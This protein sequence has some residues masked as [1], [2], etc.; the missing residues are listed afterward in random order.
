MHQNYYLIKMQ[1]L[2]RASDA[3]GAERQLNALLGRSA[4]QQDERLPARALI[5]YEITASDLA[6][7]VI[8]GMLGD[9]T[10]VAGTAFADW[11]VFSQSEDDIT[12]GEAGYWSNEYGYTTHDL[13]TRF[14]PTAHHLPIAAGGDARLVLADGPVR[15]QY[16]RHDELAPAE[17]TLTSLYVTDDDTNA[18]QIDL[19]IDPATVQRI[20]D[21]LHLCAEHNLE[22]IRFH[23]PGTCHIGMTN[24]D[25]DEHEHE[26]ALEAPLFEIE[27]GRIKIRWPYKHSDDSMWAEFDDVDGFLRTWLPGYGRAGR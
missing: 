12:D 17:V 3:Q 10:Y 11:I 1:C 16:P 9:G 18:E 26:S 23:V 7:P 25:G 2:M 8:G 15:Q 20:A 5:D 27:P 24:E 14:E 22:M 13:A 21:T 6:D 4:M 19:T